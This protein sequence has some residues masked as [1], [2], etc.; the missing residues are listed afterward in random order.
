MHGS[1]AELGDSRAEQIRRPKFDDFAVLRDLSGNPTYRDLRGFLAASLV[2]FRFNALKG[3]LVLSTSR[4]QRRCVTVSRVAVT[5]DKLNLV[6][7]GLHCSAV[8][9]TTVVGR[10]V[11]STLKSASNLIEFNVDRA[12]FVSRKVF[13]KI[14]DGSFYPLVLVIAIL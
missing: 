13:F 12:L 3:L 5:L 11:T 14:D 4:C 8:I 9:Q 6:L 7:K 1:F 10:Q 2:D